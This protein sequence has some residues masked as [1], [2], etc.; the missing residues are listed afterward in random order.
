[1]SGGLLIGSRAFVNDGE[2]CNAGMGMP[3]KERLGAYRYFEQVE[4][5]EWLDEL[6]QV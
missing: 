5:D 3:P 1:L 4:K 6:T 2:G